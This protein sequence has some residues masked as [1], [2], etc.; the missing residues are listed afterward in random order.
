M[1]RLCPSLTE[2]QAFEAAARHNSFTVAARELH[3]TQGAVS[4]QVRSLEAFLGV[5][6]FERVRQRLLLTEAG[7]RYLA[8]IR[9][10]LNEIEA[11]TVELIASQGRGGVLHIASL[12]TLGAK[13][14]IPRL[15]QFFAR[16]PEVTLEFVPHQQ[17]Y[18]FS[19][20][21]LD[22]AIRFGDG[23]WPGSLADYMTGREVLPVCRPGLLAGEPGGMA[24]TPEALL[25]YPLLHHT[26]VPEAWSEWLTELGVST[27][28]AWSG[29]RF[30]QF[31]LLTQAALSGL[32]IALIPRCL[33]E[34]ELAT[35]ALVVAH[36]A[37]VLATKGY[38][39]CYPEQKAHL[40][41]L[42]TFR[43]WLMENVDVV[44]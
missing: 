41:A 30:D 29:A 39:L 28:Q 14:L 34:E 8:R 26:T 35:G 13:W 40:P 32:G 19:Q 3:V 21:D 6:L 7:A 5:E 43:Q 23:V 38:Y 15:P 24:A 16:H 25:R 10:S 2:L 9:P 1:R 11:A 12:P 17:G 27:R 4:K 31:T 20:P 42:Q 36:S 22:A 33:I 37:R 44:A 18:D